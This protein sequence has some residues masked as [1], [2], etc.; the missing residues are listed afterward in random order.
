MNYEDKIIEIFC[1]AD[2]FCI[3][4]QEEIKKHS[5]D[6]GN[7][8][9]R[10]RAFSMSDSEVITIVVFFHLKGYRNFKHYYTQHVC[11]HM[12]KEFKTLVS[13]NRFVELMTKALLPMIM[14]LEIRCLGNCT[15]FSIIDSTPLKACHIK[16][17]HS[18]KTFKG[19]AQKGQ[20]SIGWFYGF[21]LHLIINDKGEILDFVIT[22]GNIDD[23]Q[24]LKEKNILRNIY[25]KLFGDKGYISQSLFEQLFIDGIHLITKLR[26]NMKNSLMDTKDKIMLRKRALVETVNDEL[27]NICQIEHTRHRS[28]NNFLVNLISGLIAYQ[29]LPKKPSIQCDVIDR[30]KLVPVC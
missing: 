29:F 13:Y 10:N 6:D 9:R 21:K 27:K 1:K 23:R 14:F 22:P 4:L 28:F 20:C 15:G 19:I 8:K 24:P 3:E 12:N 16:R 30:N 7:Q 25:G 5:I 2:D 26:K 18:H 11:L 17:E